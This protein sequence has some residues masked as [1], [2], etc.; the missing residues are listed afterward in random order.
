MK[1]QLDNN[2]ANGIFDSPAY[3]DLRVPMSSTKLGGSK[4]PGFAVFKTNG[5]GSQGV[6]VYWFD[7]NTEEELYFAVQLPHGWQENNL[8]PHVHWTPEVTADGT[9]AD[10][11]VEWGLE[12]TFT[13][14]GGDFSNTQI[15]YGNTHLPQDVNVVAGR[16]YLTPLTQIVP[17]ATQ[18]GLSPMLVCRLFRNATDAAD[19]TYEHDAGLLEFD[20]HIIVDTAG[21]RTEFKK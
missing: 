10:Q 15:I 17:S 6:N 21:S 16:H 3:D 11:K 9:P 4:D 8:Y 2:R 19:D 1:G 13:E 18:K 14:V 20:F 7:P 5:A 12:Y